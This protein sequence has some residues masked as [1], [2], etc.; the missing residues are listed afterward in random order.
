MKPLEGTLQ[1]KSLI[2]VVGPVRSQ[3]KTIVVLGVERGG[4]S[5]VAGMIRALGVDMGERAGRNH[6][7]PKFLTDDEAKLLQQIK[8]NNKVK[9]LWG[10]KVPKTSLMLE[11][12]DK[13]L[14]NPHYILVFRNIEATVDSWCSRGGSDPMDSALHAMKYYETALHYFRGKK[15]PL[16]FAN[17]ER[18]CDNPKDFAIN[19]ANFIGV[20]YND[21]L[22]N[23]A[24]SIVTGEGGGYLDIPEYYFHIDALDFKKWP[25]VALK[26]HINDADEHVFSVSEKKIN[27]KVIIQPDGDFFPKELYLGFTLLGDDVDLIRDQGLRIY[28]DFTGEFFPGHAFRPPLKRGKNLFKLSN[29]GNVRRIAL[30]GLKAGYKFGFENIKCF[31]DKSYEDYGIVSPKLS[32]TLSIVDRIMRKIRAICKKGS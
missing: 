2:Q 25:Q 11:F 8:I 28:M 13:H 31:K 17:Y 19:L 5:M 24:V 23:K 32:P 3:E 14:R 21:A 1:K 15:R 29:N 30:G 22:I 16:V 7:D 9:S 10:F 12:F 6:E 20:P 26:V 4:T 27:D 18:A